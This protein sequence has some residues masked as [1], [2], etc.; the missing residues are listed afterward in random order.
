MMR[1]KAAAETSVC[2][3]TINVVARIVGGGIVSDPL[4]VAGVDVR[5]IRVTFRDH[6]NEVLGPASACRGRG[7][8]SPG[9]RGSGTASGDVS[10]ANRRWFPILRKSSQA[11]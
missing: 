4:I 5:D 2:S 7:L 9:L 1:F 6:R 8:L 11:D 10:T 3:R